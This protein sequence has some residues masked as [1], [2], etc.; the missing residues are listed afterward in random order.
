MSRFKLSNQIFELGLD[1]QEMCVFAYLCSLPT[2]QRTITGETTVRVKQSTIAQNCG[3]RALQTVARIISCLQEKGLV[4]LLGRSVKVNRHKGT[5]GYAV[6]QLPLD[7][8]YFFVD[9][10]IFGML[11]PR[12]IMIYL[13]ICKSYSPTLHDCWNS[14]NDIA[15]QTGMKR[16]TVI[17]TVNELV[18]LHL[19]VRCR[20]KARD[21]KRVFVDNHYQVIFFIQ[22]SFKGKKTVRLHRNYNRTEGRLHSSLHLQYYNSTLLVKS[23]GFYRI[24]FSVRGSP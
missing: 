9:R 24:S 19:I 21:N 5:Y 8:G 7:G 22:G 17:R 1:A 6:K 4:E 15:E 11:N 16:E 14:Y 23:Q 20:R 13:F 10:H 2:A 12:Q 3:I 18:G